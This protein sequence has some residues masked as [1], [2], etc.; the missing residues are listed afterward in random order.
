MKREV[1]ITIIIVSL[2]LIVAI[3]SYSGLLTKITGYATSSTTVVNITVGNTAPTVS[4]VE[5]I[6]AKNPTDD[7]TTTITFNFTATDTDGASNINRSLAQAYFQRAGESTRS[8]TSCINTSIGVGN[9]INFTCAIDMWYYDQNG[10]WTINATI[11]DNSAAYAENSSTTFTYN[12]LPG[13]KMSPTSLTWGSVALGQSN[14]GSN[15]DPIQVNN[16]GNSVDVSI[17]VTSY[18]LRGE[19]TI[20]EFIFA[21][22]FTVE[23]TSEGCSGT[24]MS[25]ATALNVTSSIIQRGNHSLNYNNAT[26]GQEQVYFCL[27]GPLAGIS[28]QSYSSTAYG[29]WTLLII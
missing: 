1:Q 17:N 25:N 2:I 16:T 19:T 8:N 15:N 22:N 20:T 26:S 3:F 10:A 9:N 5:V 24:A 11:K 27:K 29:S 28:Q 12:L 23:N 13:M 14:T 4:A 18:N 21:S 7:T 6:A